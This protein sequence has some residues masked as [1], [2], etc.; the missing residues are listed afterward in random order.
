MPGFYQLKYTVAWANA[1][2]RLAGRNVVQF[3]YPE[4][5]TPRD[6]LR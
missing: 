5:L 2:N 6:I 3:V 4:D 1:M